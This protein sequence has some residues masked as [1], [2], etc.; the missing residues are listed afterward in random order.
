MSS[1]TDQPFSNGGLGPF[2]MGLIGGV[3]LI[4]GVAGLI[5]ELIWFRM[6]ANTFGTTGP[7]V[8]ITTAGFMAGLGIGSQ[9]M[10]RA[11][12]RSRSPALI[13]AL[14][15]GSIALIAAIMGDGIRWV[16]SAWGTWA[17]QDFSGGH[18][19]VLLIGIFFLLVVPTALM[20]ATLPVL[21]KAVVR[22]TGHLG[23]RFTWLYGMNTLG[24]ACGAWATGFY[25]IPEWGIPKTT[26]IA[27]GLNLFA[28]FVVLVWALTSRVRLGDTSR[29]AAAPKTTDCTGQRSPIPRTILFAVF[30]TGFV[31][32]AC[33]YHWTRCLIFSFDRLKN[34][35]YSFSAV[36][37]VMLIALV[38]GTSLVYWFVDR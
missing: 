33:Q 23:R 19:P 7:A 20:G 15:E 14:L 16:E 30:L 9:L 28:G 5:Y 4:S 2:G 8:A 18:D 3:F 32:L 38:L 37:S 13:Y 12:D 10:G 29:D 22:K 17:G 1:S 35:T 6:L 27:I 26:E 36:L 31:G 25:L 21:A 24:A 34:T 11:I